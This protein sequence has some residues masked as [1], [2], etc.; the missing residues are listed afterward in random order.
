MFDSGR[1]LSSAESEVFEGLADHFYDVF[2]A[3]AAES[4]G[5]G[6]AEMQERAQGR[7]WSGSRAL[8]QRCPHS[9]QPPPNVYRV[10]A[11]GFVE[12]SI[13]THSSSCP[14]TRS[15][16]QWLQHFICIPKQYLALGAEHRHAVRRLVDHLGGIYTAVA[17]VKVKAGIP[18]SSHVTLREVSCTK[19]SLRGLLSSSLTTYARAAMAGMFRDALRG[20]AAVIGTAAAPGLVALAAAGGVPSAL[21]GGAG[22]SAGNSVM[23]EGLA[24]KVGELS[25]RSLG[26][27]GD[28][29]P[30]YIMPPIDL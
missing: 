25:G 16:I 13:K 8:E 19:P 27:L 7:V 4:R 29:T 18:A 15:L 5:M 26:G 23:L 12:T 17:L 14:C 9:L 28:S 2:T 1:K 21:L 20:E 3:R 6:R 11:A 24:G 30:A 22:G 10:V